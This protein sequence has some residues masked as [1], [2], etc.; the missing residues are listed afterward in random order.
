[1]SIACLHYS[2]NRTLDRNIN[3]ERLFSRHCFELN[4]LCILYIFSFSCSVLVCCATWFNLYPPM[5]NMIYILLT[6]IHTCTHIH[7]THTHTTH[8]FHPS[9][10][11]FFI[12][13]SLGTCMF[14]SL[15]AGRHP[16]TALASSWFLHPWPVLPQTDNTL[17]LES[18]LNHWR[19][20]N[21]AV[22]VKQS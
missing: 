21:Y 22:S 1:M 10:L 14:F 6:L 17:T 8:I 9:I 4:L 2:C 19:T 3:N 11:A 15:D 5:T 18:P 20:Q 7:A 13:D 12:T 16:V